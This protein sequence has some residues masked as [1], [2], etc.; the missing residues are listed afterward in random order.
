MR[1]KLNL[2]VFSYKFKNETNF[3]NFATPHT[4][5]KLYFLWNSICMYNQSCVLWP[6]LASQE[7]IRSQRAKIIPN[8]I[9]RKCWIGIV[10]DVLRRIVCWKV[11]AYKTLCLQIFMWW[12]LLILQE[13]M[14]S[15]FT[16]YI[17]FDVKQL[18]SLF[19]IYRRIRYVFL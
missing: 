5:W 13:L 15:Y 8:K 17:Y 10:V 11:Y 18:F 3:V 6:H 9:R 12:Q 2:N 1:T 16:N 7:K 14:V 19:G 4:H